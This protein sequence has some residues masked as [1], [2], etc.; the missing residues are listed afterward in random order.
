MHTLN[1]GV[2]KLTVNASSSAVANAFT[3]PKSGLYLILSAPQIDIS[4]DACMVTQFTINDSNAFR[5][6]RQN[7][8]GGGGSTNFMIRSCVAGDK[9]GMRCTNTHNARVVFDIP[10]YAILLN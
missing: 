10:I 7:G 6:F 4:V 8:N 2:V 9:V 1:A 5:A 3:I